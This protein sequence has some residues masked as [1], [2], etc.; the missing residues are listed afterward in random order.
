MSGTYEIQPLDGFVISIVVLFVGMTL[1]RKIKIL[2]KYNIPPAVTGGLIC[3]VLVAVISLV[4]MREMTLFVMRG[5]FKVMGKDYDAAQ[6]P[7]TFDL[8]RFTRRIGAVRT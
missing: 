4:Q 7:P 1:T 6:V 2:S 3:S 8:G 5:V